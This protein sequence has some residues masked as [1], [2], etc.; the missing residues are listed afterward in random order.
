VKPVKDSR[1]NLKVLFSSRPWDAFVAGFGQQQGFKM[2]EQTKSD[3]RIFVLDQLGTTHATTPSLLPAEASLNTA[4]TDVVSTIVDRAEGVFLWVRL[5]VESLLGAGSNATTRQLEE[6]L[7]ASPDGLEELYE[8]TIER[9][10][11]S[12]HLEAFIVLEIINRASN[13]LT[14][15]EVVLAASCALGTTLDECAELVKKRLL[16]MDEEQAALQ[17]K[18]LCGGLIDTNHPRSGDTSVQFM[19]Q[20]AK[21]FVSR[22]GFEHRMLGRSHAPLYENGFSFLMKHMLAMHELALSFAQPLLGSAPERR[23]EIDILYLAFIARRAEETTGNNQEKFL[24]SIGDKRFKSQFVSKDN[25]QIPHRLIS[26][27]SFAV[28]GNLLLYTRQKLRI[29]NVVNSAS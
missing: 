4:A 3:M 12:S 19:H 23:P 9:I 13:L 5:V 10:P 16:G 1:T 20:T 27:L 11:R 8:R 22:P 21:D 6:L 24:D 17:L 15:R 26:V 25:Y 14:V 7:Q 29:A 28:L 18:N 2:H